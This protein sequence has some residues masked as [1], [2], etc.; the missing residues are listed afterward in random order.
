MLDDI[1]IIYLLGKYKLGLISKKDL[2]IGFREYIVEKGQIF[3]KLVQIILI[4]QYKWGD[5]FTDEEYF[6]LNKILDQVNMNVPEA[7]FTVGCGSVAYVYIDK[8]NSKRVIKRLLPNIIEEI[9]TSTK[10]FTNM[11]NLASTLGYNII[12]INNIDEYK[13][14]IVSQ[15]NLKK[16]AI[17]FKK[18]RQIFSKKNKIHVPMVFSYDK[19]HIV[20]ERVAGLKMTDFLIK[21]PEKKKELHSLM[22]LVIVTMIR[23]KFVH[24]DMH[25]GNF[26]FYLNENAIHVNIIDLGIVLELDDNMK[27][28]FLK[29]FRNS[30]KDKEIEYKFIYQMIKQNITYEELS[31]ILDNNPEFLGK[32]SPL[33]LIDKL[34]KYNVYFKI[35]NLNFFSGLISYRM[36]FEKELNIN[37]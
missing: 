35:E 1:Y 20:M 33:D 18:M 7:D 13:Q 31:N 8:T 3:I 14:F 21:Y 29:Y 28:I 5:F 23:N 22:I 4:N 19:N 34:R 16:E 9:N 6:E 15:T 32:I 24:A 11:I 17:N 30:K 12:D 2:I 36:R 25:E 27:D 37:K 10:K 26:L